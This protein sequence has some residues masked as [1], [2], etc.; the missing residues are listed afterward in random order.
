[1]AKWVASVMDEAKKHNPRLAGLDRLAE[2]APAER[3]AR[4]SYPSY[5]YIST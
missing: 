4:W 2:T 5:D 1:L 3:A